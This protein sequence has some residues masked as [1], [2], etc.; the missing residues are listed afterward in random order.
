MLRVLS[1][2]IGIFV[3]SPL[4]A[5]PHEQ[6]TSTRTASSRLVTI[7]HPGPISPSVSL[8]LAVAQEH[9]LFAKQGLEA[10]LVGKFPGAARLIG[11]EA[12]FGYFGSPAILAAVV[13]HGTD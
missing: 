8:P 2:V 13:E 3:A 7:A 1:L 5:Q 4:F 12:E 9:G 11:R 6:V 10:R